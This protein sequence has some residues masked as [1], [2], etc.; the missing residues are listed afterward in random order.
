MNELIE[1]ITSRTSLNAQ[2]AQE[3]VQ[4]VLDFLK[5]R[6]PGPLAAHLDSLL[7]GGGSAGGD[8]L[9]AIEGGIGS[10]FGGKH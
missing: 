2:Q 10:L 6:L 5:T 7:A 3:V 9:G 1:A 8:V 4:V